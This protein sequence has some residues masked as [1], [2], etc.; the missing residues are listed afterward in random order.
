VPPEPFVAGFVL[1]PAAV[2]ALALAANGDWGGFAVT[3][4]SVAGLVLAT[5]LARIIAR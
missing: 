2:L 1:V 5:P 4:C 3:L